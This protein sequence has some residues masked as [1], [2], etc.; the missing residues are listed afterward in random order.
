MKSSEE[1]LSVIDSL[2]KESKLSEAEKYMKTELASARKEGAWNI[3]LTILNEMAGHYRDRGMMKEALEAG[4][5]SEKIM[6]E[7]NVGKTI[8]R[9]AAYLNIANIYRAWHELDDSFSYFQKA[10]SI[11]EVCGDASVYSSYYNNLALLHQEAGKFDDAVKCLRKALEIAEEKLGDEIRTAISRTNLATSLI[12]MKRLDEAYE[13]LKP[14]I[15]IFAGRTPSD[16]HY[17]AAL[18]AMADLSLY[19]GEPE[20]ATEYF[21]AALSEIELHMGRNNF[22]NIVSDNLNR[23]YEI[24]GGRKKISGLEL[25]DRYFKTFAKPVLQKNF[26]HI[27]NHIACG[28]FGHGSECLS[29]D[30]DISKDHDYGPG[31]IIVCDDSV[32]DEDFNALVKMYDNLPKT[33]LGIKRI[34][35]VEGKNRVGVFRYKDILKTYLGMDHLPKTTE[36]WA[37]I[38]DEMSI[39]FLNGKIFMDKSSFLKNARVYMET[40]EPYF[41]YFNRVAYQLE[42]MAK[43]GQYGY[44]RAFERGDAMAALWSKTEFLKAFL[45]FVHLVCREKAPY[46]K[47]LLKSA[48]KLLENKRKRAVFLEKE[49]KSVSLMASR[50]ICPD[51]IECMENI[52]KK[53]NKL[54]LS[55]G[56]CS[57]TEDYLQIKA[58]EL[59]HLAANTVIA[60][61][62]VDIEW[63]L[64][65]KTQNEGKRADCQDNWSTFSIMR[66]SQYY[67]WPKELLTLL[68][69]DYTEAAANGRNVITE[70]YGYMMESTA[71]D[72]YAKI[73]DNLPLVDEDKQKVIEAIASIQVK[74]REEFAEEYPELSDNARL[75]HTSEDTEYITSY[76]TYLRGE[77]STYHPD[78]L[79]M[80]GQFVAQCASKNINLTKMIMNM[81]TFF[82]GYSS[83]DGI[84]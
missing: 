55:M 27:E 52:C 39:L 8:E 10:Y 31:F 42:L 15:D 37:T 70:K 19:R 29:F 66:R 53:V 54:L 77:L 49:I 73:K 36:E 38:S 34:E 6:D 16:F 58:Y 35:T 2:H 65:D 14:A 5:E 44:K 20:K 22:Y 64:F 74:W 4:L 84:M 83:L 81:T 46:E 72:S 45:C 60:D 32:S 71:P 3:C 57:G 61:R 47:W 30:D 33:Y 59:K 23:A 76:E 28:M 69:T 82:Y 80:Y 13:Y 18:S 43:H 26:S 68:L 1:I 75:I 25:S 12:R 9:A 78:T 51:D 40:G 48:M 17:S 63:A 79:T 7:N 24:A 11:I 56:I 62:I 50:G 41:V 67:C 21:E